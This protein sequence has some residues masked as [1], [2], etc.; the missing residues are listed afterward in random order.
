[1]AWLEQRQNQFHVCLRIGGKK[2]KRSLK[3]ADG[4]EAE[5]VVER[6][7][8]RL[9]LVE[10]GDLSI[11]PEAD[12]LMFLL[13]DGKLSKSVVIETGLSLKDACSRWKASIPQGSLEANTLYTAQIHLR[14][15]QSVLGEW[16]RF[17][18]LKFADLQRYVDER[19]KAQGR[20][21]R[22][23]SPTTIRKEL[24]TLSGVWTW[25]LTMGL[26][27]G[28][29][30]NRGLRYSKSTEK[31]PF[32]T[33]S[34]IERHVAEGTLTQDEETLLWKCLYLSAAEID[35]LLEFVQTRA[36]HLFLFPMIV[37]AAHTGARRSELLRSQRA[38]FDFTANAVTIREKKRAKGRQTCRTVPLTPRLRLVMKFHLKHSSGKFTFSDA[39]EPIPV[40]AATRGLKQALAGSRWEKISGWHVFRHSFISICA[41]MGTDQR[42]IDAWSGHQTEEMRRRY[43][44]LFPD[45]QQAAIASVFGTSQ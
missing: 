26:V 23:L 2:L 13:T 44:H 18:Q 45:A 39:A 42:M 37:M 10:Q 17:D 12:V 4:D 3:T 5:R 30:P 11:P 9:K 34:E 7:E 35:Q 29:F 15:L 25:C 22:P 41:S 6:I 20:Y 43:R 28:A 36:H 8:R 38:D 19:S 33:W 27:K 21:G 1:M 31:S 40:D 32:Q 16:L 24:V 14:H